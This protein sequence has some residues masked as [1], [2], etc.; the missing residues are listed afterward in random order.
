[1]I[2]SFVL[3]TGVPSTPALPFLQALQRDLR[4]NYA[5]SGAAR[6]SATSTRSPSPGSGATSAAR[7]ADDRAG[8]TG[9]ADVLSSI[10]GQ[11]SGTPEQFATLVALVARSLGVPARVV[12]GFRAATGGAVRLAA[13]THTLDTADAWT[14]AE[15][16]IVGAGWV[17]LDAAPGA[18]SG[19]GP[20]VE[21]AG[22][23][24]P[25]SSPPPR[26]NVQITSANGGHAVARK[27]TVPGS[28]TYSG[29][30][31]LI[32]LLIV[33]AVVLLVL[34]LVLA[35]RKRVRASKRRRA[36]DPR[37]Q[38]LGAWQESIDM[39]T[40]SGL[41][42]LSSR[43][44]AEIA[45]LASEQFGAVPG[46]QAAALGRRANSVAYSTRR[47]VSRDDVDAAWE[48]ER[49]LRTAVRRQLGLRDRV[50]AAARYHRP[51][52]TPRRYPGRRRR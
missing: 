23:P 6:G 18:Y 39:L 13:G 11:R 42:E 16:P 28:A 47:I 32:A 50:A 4:T 48:A 15:V 44:N 51:R 45:E 31:L 49:A 29:H 21:S 40:E 19:S 10:L 2:R 22:A 1:M 43:T 46:D 12:T 27:S 33:V 14:W 5:L 26:Q 8:G 35:C 38:L 36:K 20:P 7:A 24:S 25:S 41:P 9:F 34:L 3:E 30:D 37:T 17:V 52:A